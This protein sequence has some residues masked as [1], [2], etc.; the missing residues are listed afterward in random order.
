MRIFI[1]TMDD[2]ILTKKFISQIIYARKED[3]I[4]VAVPKG[5]RLTVRKGKSKNMYLLSLFL[6]MG[7][8]LFFKYLI[9]SLWHNL[10]KLGYKYG[11]NADPTILGYASRIGIP[12]FK[13][14]TP[15]NK[16]FCKQLNALKPDIIINQS[17]HIIKK[18]LL[19]IPTIGVLNRHNALLPRNRGRLTPFWVIFKNETETGVSIHFVEEGI[20]SGDII[21]QV[22]YS[23]SKKDT[24]NTLVKKNYKI[25]PEAMIK[26]L[27]LLENGFKDFIHNNDEEATYNSTPSLREAWQYRK[28]KLF[29]FFEMGYIYLL[30]MINFS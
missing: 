11:L 14:D 12:T 13:I 29:R 22:K 9:I 4:G 7:H 8:Y 15:N 18:E 10:K 1:I 24:F 27:D 2:P 26:A 23:V 3:I 21:V 30:K 16:E 5:G 17:Q 25:A 6:I 28:L 20:D 19:D